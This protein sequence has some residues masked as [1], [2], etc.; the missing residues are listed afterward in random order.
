MVDVKLPE[1]H[2]NTFTNGLQPLAYNHC[3]K[4]MKFSI[5]DFLSKCE[6]IRRKLRNQSH[7][8]KESLT[9]NLISCAVIFTELKD[10]AKT[11]AS[12]YGGELC[13]GT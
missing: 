2:K 11:P 4:K 10:A 9:E 6:Q 1:F 5:K 3:T 13:N 12:I 7:L 8:L